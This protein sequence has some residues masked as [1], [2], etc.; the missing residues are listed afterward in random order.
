MFYRIYLLLS[1]YYTNNNNNNI[2]YRTKFKI[3][4]SNI[5]TLSTNCVYVYRKEDRYINSKLASF[6]IF[7][8][9]ILKQI[10]CNDD[11]HDDSFRQYKTIHNEIKKSSHII[12][13]A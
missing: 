9:E 6:V 10:N 8:F 5:L 11:D 12:F 7:Q 2:T 1:I 3:L 13:L 4:I